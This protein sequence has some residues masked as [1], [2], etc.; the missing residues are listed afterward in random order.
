MLG[1][2]VGL[3]ADHV[4]V[5]GIDG[6]GSAWLRDSNTPQ[7]EKL[8]A[9]GASTLHARAVIPTVSSPN[10]ASM[11][12]GATP[13]QHGVTSNEWQPDKHEI[14]PVCKGPGPFFPTIFGVVRQQRH[15]TTIGVFHHWK[16]FGRLVEKGSANQVVHIDSAA[17]TTEAAVAY[18]NSQHPALLFVHLDHVDHAGHEH[19]WGSAEYRK[20]VE[21]ADDYVGQISEA[22]R[23]AVI[24]VTADH[25][26][27]G[28]KHGGLTIGEIEIPW[29][30]A[31]PGIRK[32]IKLAKPVNTYDTA[33]TIAYLLRI[34]PHECWTGR[35]LQEALE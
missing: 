22:A 16:G 20:A 19:G 33:A 35:P 30:A 25:G 6:L 29:I 14:P 1:A 11:I 5:I 13:A 4:I 31:G 15:A 34:K 12:N 17:K 24:I 26:G 23:D 9:R 8:M 27:S 10:W 21:E 18:W 7:L 3:A 2:A 32:G 28:T